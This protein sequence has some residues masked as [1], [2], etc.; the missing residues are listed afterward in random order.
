M[1]EFSMQVF[2]PIML[3]PL[4]VLLVMVASGSIFTLPSMV[5]LVMVPFVSRLMNSS[6]ILALAERMSSF[7]PVSSHHVLR[8]SALTLK[9]MLTIS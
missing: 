1:N 2:F 6:R 7:L 9:P 8:I 4:I 3:G 5:L